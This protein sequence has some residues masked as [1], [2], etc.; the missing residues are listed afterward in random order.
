VANGVVYVGS[1]DGDLYAL[2]T[3][4]GTRLSGT[5]T[6]GVVASSPAVSDG[7]VYAGSADGKLYAFN[8]AAGLQVPRRPGPDS[9]HPDRRLAHQR[10]DLSNPAAAPGRQAVA[11]HTE[12]GPA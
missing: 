4:T 7:T 10:A 2:S 1:A 5:A 6:G 12:A 8:L 11:R 9:L 3:A